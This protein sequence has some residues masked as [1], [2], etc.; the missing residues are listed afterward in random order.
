MEKPKKTD[1]VL[2][3]RPRPQF[4]SVSE[5]ELG[6][7]LGEGALATVRLATHKASGK[8]YA[9]KIIELDELGESDLLNIEKE[10][11]IHSKIDC[12]FIIKMYD[13]FKEGRM[14]YM[15]LE[16]ASRGNM[17]KF[18]TKN[19][20]LTEDLVLTRLWTQTVLAIQYL[21]NKNI[22]M[23][24]LKPEN[25]L[26]NENL[27][28]KLCDFGWATHLSDTE[29]RKLQGGTFVYMSPETLKGEEQ[30]KFSDVWSL[31]ILIFELMHNREPYSI[32][33]TYDE[34]M[35]FIEVQR[36]V[37]AKSTSRTLSDL[38]YKLLKKDHTKRPTV[39]QILS[40]PYIQP[41][42][43]KAKAGVGHPLPNADQYKKTSNIKPKAL[44]D[45]YNSS[46]NKKPAKI[47]MHITQGEGQAYKMNST[48][49]GQTS[50]HPSTVL[51]PSNLLAVKTN[52]KI[53]NYLKSTSVGQNT[54]NSIVTNGNQISQR[55]LTTL[56]QVRTMSTVNQPRTQTDQSDSQRQFINENVSRTVLTNIGK[57]ENRHIPY[58]QSTQ[59]IPL[60]NRNVQ[61]HHQTATSDPR[62]NASHPISQQR[63]VVIQENQVPL[64]RNYEEPK[65][66][67]GYQ[68]QTRQVHSQSHQVQNSWSNVQNNNQHRV[69][70]TQPQ[71]HLKTP[72]LQN[73]NAARAPLQSD[74]SNRN[75]N[76]LQVE[77]HRS[78]NADSTMRRPSQSSNMKEILTYY[79]N[80]DLEE[81]TPTPIPASN[82]QPSQFNFS[83]QGTR[84]LARN[85]TSTLDERKN[86]PQSMSHQRTPLTRQHT[87]V[88]YAQTATGNPMRSFQIKNQPQVEP[89][90]GVRVN[91]FSAWQQ[92]PNEAE[93]DVKTVQQRNIITREYNQDR[94]VQVEQKVESQNNQV[95]HQHNGNSQ[96]STNIAAY[97]QTSNNTQRLQPNGHQYIRRAQ[98]EL[99]P[100]ALNSLQIQ[101]QTKPT[102]VT[103]Q[104]NMNIPKLEMV[105]TPNQNQSQENAQNRVYSQTERNIVYNYQRPTGL[106]DYNQVKPHAKVQESHTPQR[107][108]GRRIISHS[109]NKS[110]DWRSFQ[111]KEVVQDKQQSNSNRMIQTN[112]GGEQKIQVSRFQN[113]G[114]TKQTVQVS[115]TRNG[116]LMTSNYNQGST[117]INGYRPSDAHRGRTPTIESSNQQ[118]T[119]RN[120]SRNRIIKLSD[121]RPATIS[122]RKVFMNADK[123]TAPSDRLQTRSRV[124][125]PSMSP[126]P[127]QPKPQQRGMTKNRSYNDLKLYQRKLEEIEAEEKRASQKQNVVIR[128]YSGTYSNRASERNRNQATDQILVQTSRARFLTSHQGHFGQV[129]NQRSYGVDVRQQAPGLKRNRS[130]RKI[131]LQ[132]YKIKSKFS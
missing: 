115:S 43:E 63:K 45:I 86:I 120:K 16:Y 83:G 131:K 54:L 117:A 29:Y 127:I 60:S 122:S 37:F 112:Q 41:F 74:P 9:L 3:R 61:A 1:V 62:L 19:H 12:P 103:H 110:Y 42:V 36:V 124:E 5:F 108:S 94:N 64:Q 109:K 113:E 55:G 118:N 66:W 7:D 22:I 105:S 30:G 128:E 56:N 28:V 132:D 18:L 57:S 73:Q 20:P 87:P 14:L 11:E 48:N 89:Q 26:L 21:H 51:H 44:I 23:R 32:G 90:E 71:T 67:S 95:I 59:A 17:F 50:N 35:Y 104:Q 77:S 116:Q 81:Q 91:Q 101:T 38:I 40:D 65:I 97:I 84:T 119:Q 70:T 53:Q 130:Y 27:N 15:V 34:Q 2:C 10:L 78:S 129:Q 33:D 52:P 93:S 46:K 4:H 13:F 24:D 125:Q 100:Q 75:T 123:D 49:I 31:G 106:N 98:S 8:K 88:V 25:I 82:E 121:Y 47:T 102:T 107:A 68:N 85:H 6:P 58:H 96:R 79:Q 80:R 99:N 126:N 114:Q 76:N 39:H 111:P 69:Y 92:T 72:T